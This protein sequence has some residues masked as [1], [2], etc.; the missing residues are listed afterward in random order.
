MRADE[1]SS[2]IR[3]RNSESSKLERKRVPPTKRPCSPRPSP[4]MSPERS[5]TAKASPFFR[6][7]LR[8]SRRSEVARM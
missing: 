8:S 3:E 7:R 1:P 2:S 5:T 4:W 6:T